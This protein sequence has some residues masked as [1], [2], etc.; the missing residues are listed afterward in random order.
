MEFIEGVDLRR[1]LLDHGKLAPAEAV[2]LIRQVCFALHAAHT[3]GVIHRD[4]KPQNI[5]QDKQGRILVMDFGLARSVGSE[6][7][8]QTGALVGTMEYMSPEQ[9]MGSDLD[10]KSDI[11]ALGLI[12]FELLTAKMPYKADTALASLLKRNQERA[13]PAV[14]MDPSI[15]KGLSDI[16][17][18]CLERD[19][20]ERYQDVQDIL[21]DLDAWRGKRPVSASTVS[22]PVP[23]APKK[24]LPWKLIAAGVL[25]A[26]VVAGGWM[27]RGRIP[28][29]GSKT[30]AQGPVTSLAILPFRNASGD[31]SL[32]WL[33][34]TVA[35][36]L[37]TDMGESAYLRTVPS[38]RVNQILHDLR[39]A[40]DAALDPDTLHRVAEF[41]SADRL[42]S[43]QYVKLGDQ[44][45]IDAT[46]QD[47]KGRRNFAMK[48]EAASEKDLPKALEQLAESVEKALALPPETIKEIQAKTLKPSTQSVQALRYYSEG[49]Q[50]ARQGKNLEAVKQF[51]AATKEDPG[52][53]LAY[54]KLG[55]TYAALGYGDKAQEAS[56][57]AVDLS[58]KVSPQEKYLIEAEDAR[59]SRNL[60]KAIASYENLVKVLPDDLDVQYALARLYE[61]SDSFDKARAYYQNLLARDPKNLDALLHMGWVEIR[62]DNPQGSL[63]YLNRGFTLAV[64]LGNDEEKGAILDAI[65]NAYQ[66]LNKLDDAIR[67]YQGSLDVKRRLD[68]NRGIAETL[69]WMA[70]AQQFAGKSEQA[71]KSYQEAIRLRRMVGDKTGLGGN[72]LDLGNFYESI[73]KYDQ[74][75]SYAKEALPLIRET[76][77]RQNEG[78]CL[79][80]IGWIYLDKA[81]YENAMTYF[82]QALDLRQKF[83]SPADVAD[84]TYNLGDVFFRTGQYNQGMDYY[85]KA[86]D[87]WRK[88]G[89]KRG[90]AFASFGLGRLF[91]YQG[92]YGAA[93]TSGEDALKSWREV[94]ERGFWLPEIQAGYGNALTL[95]GRGDD[96]Q[97]NLDEALGLARELK[98]NSL[99]A[100][101]LNF[102][103][104]RLFYRGDFKSARGWFEQASQVA[105]KTTDREQ[106]LL[107]K[108]NVAKVSVKEGRSQEAIKALKPLAEEADRSGLKYLAVDSSIYLAQALL[109]SKDYSR[110]RQQLED[111]LRVSEKLGLQALL[112]KSHYFLAEALRLGGSQTEASHHYAEARR[113]LDDIRKEAHSDEVLKRNDL[114][115]IYQESARWQ[116]PKT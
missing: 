12:F 7:M 113:I 64:Q 1:L 85:L 90:A 71:L 24:V 6:G 80:N 20:K 105:A 34:T 40:P 21:N 46:L 111:S 66:H 23:A 19:L 84:T 48:A 94:N 22:T 95:I 56:R 43:G 15:P 45:R 42:L 102:Q 58:D 108:F 77:D 82:Q 3:V 81:D 57:K 60:A 39:V 68:D 101:I 18:K 88:S 79:N 100:R 115:T 29:K 53:A 97:K 50:L 62:T 27:L 110:A 36:M 99:V 49:L 65:G 76:G 30:P 8:T 86:L 11:F 96:A 52:F 44:I 116:N 47:L 25:A 14:D 69:N 106:I 91:Q 63:D 32:N 107:A 83:G 5:M 61:D 35:Q 51:E 114:A 72:L 103:G 33:G 98:N 70:E 74:A 75:L 92:R 2:D 17:G 59:V 13:V 87:L 4:L 104:D 16:V 28:S 31:S 41:T 26:V 73:G 89:D 55:G 93:V 54:S 67:S 9:A 112:A 78:I 10:Q 37:S 38:D 109:D